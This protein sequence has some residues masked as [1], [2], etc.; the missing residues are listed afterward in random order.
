M[1]QL[2]LFGFTVLDCT[3]CPAEFKISAVTE[4]SLY[5]E[6]IVPYNPNICP[7]LKLPVGVI[8]LLKEIF[9]FIS[10]I[11]TLLPLTPIGNAHPA[12]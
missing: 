5:V 1:L 10:L 2:V 9:E 4:E 12:Y 11:F 3:A 8:M 6:L 7:W